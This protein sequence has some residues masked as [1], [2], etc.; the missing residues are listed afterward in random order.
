MDFFLEL[1]N[2]QSC[3]NSILLKTYILS[4]GINLLS[5]EKKGQNCLNK[6]SLMRLNLGPNLEIF[7]ISH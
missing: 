3:T 4:L 7:Y 2:L 1:H 5:T 6:I